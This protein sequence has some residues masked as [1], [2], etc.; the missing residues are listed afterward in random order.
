MSEGS[1]K[2]DKQRKAI[3]LDSSRYGLPINLQ[4]EN[5]K[6]FETRQEPREMSCRRNT[7]EMCVHRKIKWIFFLPL[8]ALYN[9]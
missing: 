2:T 7:K 5:V 9:I 1:G 8:Y 3:N 4:V 6:D